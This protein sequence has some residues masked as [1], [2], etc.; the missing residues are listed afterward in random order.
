M[1]NRTLAIRVCASAQCEFWFTVGRDAW[2]NVY[3][4]TPAPYRATGI[5]AA[6]LWLWL[7][8]LVRAAVGPVLRGGYDGDE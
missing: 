8:A 5:R 4:Y 6:W 7:V 1:R 2:R 3:G